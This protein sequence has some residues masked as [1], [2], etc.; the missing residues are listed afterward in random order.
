ML[1]TDGEN[2]RIDKGVTMETPMEIFKSEDGKV[3]VNVIIENETAWLTQARWPNCSAC[4]RLP[5]VST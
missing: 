3:Q 4:R 1:I 5:S 2:E